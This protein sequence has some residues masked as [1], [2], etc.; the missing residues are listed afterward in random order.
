VPLAVEPAAARARAYSLAEIADQ[1][2]AAAGAG[3]VTLVP[4]P[5]EHRNIAIGSFHTDGTL[6]A[7]SVGWSATTDLDLGL[8]RT[9]AFY[10]EHPWYLSS[11]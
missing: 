4:W 5:A 1:V 2:V 6:I 3:R 8:Q 11:T 10:R 9:M 7:A